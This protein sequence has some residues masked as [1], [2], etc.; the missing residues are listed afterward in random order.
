[1]I[2]GAMSSPMES[3]YYR[4]RQLYCNEISVALVA[5]NYGTLLCVYRQY[6][7]LGISDDLKVASVE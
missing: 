7:I 5:E 4:V 2:N 3:F 1:M 6:V